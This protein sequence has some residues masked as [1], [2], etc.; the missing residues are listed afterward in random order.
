MC[1]TTSVYS[2]QLTKTHSDQNFQNFIDATFAK[3]EQVL[4][5]K[6]L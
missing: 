1:S 6:I 5:V 4:P 2:Q 3:Q